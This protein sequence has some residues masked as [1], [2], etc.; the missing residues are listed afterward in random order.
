VV[1]E[2]GALLTIVMV[3]VALPLVVGV[4]VTV[5][6]V[7]EPWL[8]VVGARFVVNAPE[9]IVADVMFKV[10]LP[11][12]VRVTFWVELL[13]T[14]TPLVNET[15]EGFKLICACV[16]TEV[17]LNPITKGDPG[18]LLLTETLPLALP[19]VVGANVALNVVLEPGVSVCAD[20]PLMLNPVPLALAPVI[21][22]LA[23]PLFVS[24][25]FTDA[26]F[27]VITEPKFT[28]VGL[29]LIAA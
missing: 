1:G 9:L 17:P 14:L 28:L 6:V 29:A 5:N 22:R 2:V 19:V 3:P 7:F 8:T 27:P 23:V 21:E 24:V 12:F 13:P 15:D 4:N 20:K 25:T 10:A 26:V 18:A 16:A 11:V